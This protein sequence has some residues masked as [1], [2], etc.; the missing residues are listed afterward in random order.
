M[1]V[2]FTEVRKHDRVYHFSDGAFRISGVVRYAIPNRSHRLET[3]DGRKFIVRCGWHAI[4]LVM[5]EWTN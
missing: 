2:E 5:D 1:G 4:E 3:E